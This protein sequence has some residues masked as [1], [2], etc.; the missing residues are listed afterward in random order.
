MWLRSL[1]YHILHIPMINYCYLIFHTYIDLYLGSICG[2]T[3]Q[4]SQHIALCFQVT[5]LLQAPHGYF[6]GPGLGSGAYEFARSRPHRY[7]ST[8][9]SCLMVLFFFMRQLKEKEEISEV[10]F[11]LFA[12]VVDQE[13]SGDLLLWWLLN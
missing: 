6:D 9:L 8:N 12:I 3:A 10:L 4:S 13:L 5:A 7:V 11:S 2:T 1:A